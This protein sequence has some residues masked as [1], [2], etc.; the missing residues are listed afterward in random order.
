M[1]WDIFW[2]WLNS[3]GA[4]LSAAVAVLTAA[5]AIVALALTSRDSRER[6]RPVMLAEFRTA[7]H[8]DS[9]IDLVVRNAGPSVACDVVVTFD[10]LPVIPEQGGPYLTTFLLQRYSRLVPTV[11]PGQEFTNIWWSGEVRG[12]SA[13]LV[14]GEPTPDAVTVT[15]TYRGG[16]SRPYTDSY[17]LHVDIVK[18]QTFSVDSTSF[19]G[20]MNSIVKSLQ[21]VDGAL[22][23]V[24]KA[25][26]YSRRDQVAEQQASLVERQERRR[27]HLREPA[28][29]SEDGPVANDEHK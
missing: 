7:E 9:T 1:T 13:E 12:S 10:P 17:K 28:A 19:P 8:S 16:R 5:V 29:A 24:A 26:D 3:N 11:G 25:A 2:Q 4:G 15:I 6:S 18:M 20:Q 27:Q 14:N 22:E 23:R 21:K